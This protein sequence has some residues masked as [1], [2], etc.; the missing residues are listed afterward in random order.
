[1][2][3]KKRIA[4]TIPS[5]A[6]GGAERVATELANEFIKHE[7]EVSIILLDK[8]EIYYPLSKDVKVYFNAYNEKQK[9]AKRN[10]E[11]IK[12]LKNQKIGTNLQERQLSW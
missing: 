9:K 11:R 4:I 2:I 12:K 3:N 6:M 7:I 5:L 8:N 10:K 1:M